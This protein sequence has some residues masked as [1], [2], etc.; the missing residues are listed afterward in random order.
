MIIIVL[1]SKSSSI[2]AA[3]LTRHMGRFNWKFSPCK[4]SFRQAYLQF[5]PPFCGWH[6]HL[7]FFTN[8]NIPAKVLC[9]YINCSHSRLARMLLT[10]SYD[11]SQLCFLCIFL[12]CWSQQEYM[13]GVSCDNQHKHTP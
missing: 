13:R 8:A 5:I 4:F 6:F 9:V 3:F 10:V 11:L 2:L 1:S 7:S 12:L